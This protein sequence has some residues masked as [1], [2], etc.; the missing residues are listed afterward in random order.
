[1]EDYTKCYVAG[2]KLK[3]AFSASATTECRVKEMRLLVAENQSLCIDLRLVRPSTNL[4]YPCCVRNT[5]A[6]PHKKVKDVYPAFRVQESTAHFFTI[7]SPLVTYCR[8]DRVHP[9]LK[10]KL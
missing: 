1:M 10:K 7:I 2:V 4:P 8:A 9:L 6:K 5:T 3:S